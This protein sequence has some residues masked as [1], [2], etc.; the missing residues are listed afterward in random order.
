MPAQ[1]RIDRPRRVAGKIILEYSHHLT[2]LPV[3]AQG[4]G[5][6]WESLP[7]LREQLQNLREYLRQPEVMALLTILGRLEAD[8][9]LSALANLQGR[10]LTFDSAS[11]TS[12]LAIT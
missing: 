8:P 3:Q 1:L 10:I 7:D 4:Y 12:P 6:A 5:L 11:L 9:T 2:S